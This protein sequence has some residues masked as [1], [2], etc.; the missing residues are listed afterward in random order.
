MS[1]TK[2][3]S[4]VVT[5]A[6]GF[7]GAHLCRS[8][9]ADGVATYGFDLVHHA[10]SEPCDIFI[11]DIRRPD[12]LESFFDRNTAQVVF[13]LAARAEV[14][15]PLDELPTLFATNINATVNVLRAAP[16][17]KVIFASSSAVYGT[18]R[19]V[20]TALWDD[21]HPLG[22]YG[23]SKAAAEMACQEWA[24]STGGV[25]LSFRFGNVI[26]A[27]CRGLIP[28]LVLH[29]IRFPNGSVKAQMRGHGNLIR[30][31]VPVQ[32]V[33][34]LMKKAAAMEWPPATS[35]AFNIGTGR[36]TTNGEIAAIVSR[37]LS[38]YGYALQIDFD[39]PAM[40]G[41]SE[42]I[43]LDVASTPE[44]FGLS[45]PGEQEITDAI[46]QAILHCLRVFTAEGALP[47]RS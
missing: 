40:P 47:G 15:V 4:A 26:G 14:V 1:K 30:D 27:G 43:V 21:V 25:A 42:E 9:I 8:L 31:Y 35:R 38:E 19:K 18:A 6:T 23:L 7:I 22:S 36:G 11:G 13:H 24:R 29:A 41:E 33:V 3:N 45:I 17:Q 32:H 5:G 39:N 12:H 46:K 34:D 37:V 2:L 20:V 10:R 16:V 28:Y 44:T